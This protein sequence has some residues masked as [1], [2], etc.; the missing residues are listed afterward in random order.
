MGIIK[1]KHSCNAGDLISIL[2]GI[3]HAYDELGKKGVVYQRL[4]MPGDYY[5]GAQHP[6]KNN[7]IQV[8]CNQHQFDMLKPLIEAQEYIESFEIWKGQDVDVDFDIIREGL[9]S[10]MPA[11]SINRWVWYAFPT[12][13]C[14]LSIKSINAP[15][16]G[17]DINKIKDKVI[18][19][20][21]SRYRN[22]LISYFF[23]KEWESELIFAGTKDEHATFCSDYE[24]NIP[25]LEVSNFLEL[26]QYI[27][28]CKFLLSN[29]SMCWNLAENLKKLRVLEVCKQAPNCVP[30][31]AGGYDF[32]QQGALEIYFKKFIKQ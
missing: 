24:L 4:N 11:G 31:G 19:N 10:T 14:D 22:H 25:Y 7:D 1:Y 26:A 15:R 17:F 9:Y 12:L 2:P 29:Q 30:N 21:T 20:L 6:V 18:V 5:I 27:D 3:K 32:L 28:N 16:E 23:L 8:C 13:A